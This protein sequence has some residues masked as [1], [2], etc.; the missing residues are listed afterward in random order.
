[1]KSPSQAKRESGRCGWPPPAFAL[2][3]LKT[4]ERLSLP[5]A[6]KQTRGELFPT[7]RLTPAAKRSIMPVVVDSSSTA[8]G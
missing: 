8:K 3:D 1:M 5:S 2:P 6:G 7:P 4:L